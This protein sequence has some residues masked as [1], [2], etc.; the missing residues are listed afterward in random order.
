MGFFFSSSPHEAHRSRTCEGCVV[1]LSPGN[2]P[3][4]R[5]EGLLGRDT[6]THTP[7]REGCSAN[8]ETT[9]CYRLK[10]DDLK[11]KKGKKLGHYFCHCRHLKKSCFCLLLPSQTGS[12][13]SVAHVSTGVASRN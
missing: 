11:G 9:V 10:I 2:P 3:P 12:S 8:K 7:G 5:N 4:G 6:Q 1:E 13:A